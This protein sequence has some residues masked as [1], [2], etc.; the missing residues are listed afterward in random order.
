MRRGSQASFRVSAALFRT[1]AAVIEDHG[2]LQLVGITIMAIEQIGSF[3]AMAMAGQDK[4]H[5]VTLQDGER[6]GPHL[7]KFD[8][9]IRVVRA[10]CV[11]RMV[12]KRARTTRIM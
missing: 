12:P 1:S 9:I 5:S 7:D 11:G 8:L 3:V 2:A 4:I 10:L 6:I